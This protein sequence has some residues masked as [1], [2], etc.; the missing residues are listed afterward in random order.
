M[1]TREA[2]TVDPRAERRLHVLN[3]VLAGALSAAQAAELLE[4]SLRQVRRLLASYRAEGVA[5]LVH[6]NRA[7]A[8]ANR[9]D[10]ELLAQLVELASSTYAGVNRAHLAELLAEREGIMVAQRSLRRVL[11][12]A[13]TIHG[14]HRILGSAHGGDRIAGRVRGQSPWPSTGR[15]ALRPA[16]IDLVVSPSGRRDP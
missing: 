2:I 12:E 15:G 16:R 10:S 6:G 3:H 14:A 1:E 9:L 11:T 8:P 4:L 13:L 5:A 7:R